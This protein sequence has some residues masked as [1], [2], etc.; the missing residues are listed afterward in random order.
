MN[1]VAHPRCYRG[2][3]GSLLLL[4]GT[5]LLTVA[6]SVTTNAQ[7]AAFAT[8]SGTVKDQNHAV[9]AGAQ[10][11]AT[12]KGT[13]RMRQTT[14]NGEGLFVLTNLPADEYEV[15]IHA[16]GFA[17]KTLNVVLQVGQSETL[18]TVL[19]VGDVTASSGGITADASA[20]LNTGPPWST[21]SQQAKS[22][23]CRSTGV[24]FK[25][26]PSSYPVTHR[27]RISIPKA[28]WDH[29]QPGNWVV[30]AT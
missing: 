28:A 22:E 8:L 11:Q 13:R 17:D 2:I 5:L 7:Q 16:T 27:L 23:T 3:L 12:R 20:S 4:L 9:V 18:T 1:L 19:S 21:G 24:T 29:H 26:S 15:K 30:A 10:I 25:N 14:T 6:Q